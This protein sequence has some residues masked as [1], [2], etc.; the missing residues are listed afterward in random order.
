MH[1]VVFIAAVLVL[2]YAPALLI[3]Q[4]YIYLQYGYWVPLPASS[5]FEYPVAAHEHWHHLGEALSDEDLAVLRTAIDSL[6]AVAPTSLLK[7]VWFSTPEP[8]TWIGAH[9]LLHAVLDF[10]SISF[11][12]LCAAIALFV[13]G[14]SL[15]AEETRQKSQDEKSNA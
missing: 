8:K 3:Y 12:A 15:H 11:A 5:I 7:S 6:D 14:I 10:A 4:T 1:V 2:L 13:W 9:R